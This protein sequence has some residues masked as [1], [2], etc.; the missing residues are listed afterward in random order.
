MTFSSLLIH[1]V[2][3]FNRPDVP[4]VT[5]PRYGNE[6]DIW[7]TGT[8]SPARVDER[9]STENV[10]DRETRHKDYLVFFPPT[11]TISALSYLTWNGHELRVDG[12]P[13]LKYDAQGPHHYEVKCL[14]VLG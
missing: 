9:S 1:T 4:V 10:T 3:I 8:P 7:D 13:E 2:T 14:E 6:I 12:E 5:D 11:V